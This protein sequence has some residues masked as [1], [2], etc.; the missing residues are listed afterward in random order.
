MGIVLPS[1]W[2]RD[3]IQTKKMK[4][5]SSILSLAFA[6]INSV[7]AQDSRPAETTTQ[8]S[9]PAWNASDDFFVGVKAGVNFANVYDSKGEEFNADTKLGFVAGGFMCIPI[10]RHLSIQPE[11]LFSQKGFHATGRILGGLYDF[12]R[13]TNY[14]D[15]PIYL[16][17]LAG[18]QY[19]YLLK[20]TD[21]FK[22]ATSTIEQE[23]EF[24]N[25]NIRKNTFALIT[26]L[27]VNLEPAVLSARVGWDVRNNSGDG[28]STTPRYKNVWLQT[29]LGFRF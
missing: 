24:Q 28:T 9:R 12:K 15:I 6:L 13:T 17:L 26:G 16:A 14:I 23:K 3:R 10:I 1:A 8:S 11:L 7:M 5:T 29:T 25:D 20:Q 2:L 19:S 27:D 4:K 18:P 22:N 21:V